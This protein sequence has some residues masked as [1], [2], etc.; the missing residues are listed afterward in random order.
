[1]E[2][3]KKLEDAAKECLKDLKAIDSKVSITEGNLAFLESKKI[4]LTAE[5]SDLEGKKAS[6]MESVGTVEKEAREKIDAGVRELR[7]K[8]DQLIADRAALKTKLYEA[9]SSKVQSDEAREK[10]TA[11]Y[12]EC[13]VAT[14]EMEEKKQAILAAAGK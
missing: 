9:E 5:I 10:Y 4:K 3:L 6:V 14:K 11:A 2:S 13:L 1:M 8:E 7:L 12:A